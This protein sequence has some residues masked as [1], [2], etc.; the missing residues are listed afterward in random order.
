MLHRITSKKV[1]GS[2]VLP[3]LHEGLRRRLEGSYLVCHTA[4]DRGALGRALDRYDL[5]PLQG[6]WLDSARI[7]R[8]AWPRLP[9]KGLPALAKKLKIE[10]RHHDAAQEAKVAAEVVVAASRLMGKSISEWV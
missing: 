5:P 7:A 2:P 8:A 1:A 3:D 6:T 4:F 10:F 9:S